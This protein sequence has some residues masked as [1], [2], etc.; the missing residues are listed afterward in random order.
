MTSSRPTST[1]SAAHLV[2][3]YWNMTNEHFETPLKSGDFTGVELDFPTKYVHK[4]HGGTFN[5]LL[6]RM[7]CYN[8][9]LIDHTQMINEYPDKSGLCFSRLPVQPIV[10]PRI[11]NTTYF[12]PYCFVLQDN[13]VNCCFFLQCCSR[14]R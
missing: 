13:E 8:R 3:K 6:L 4:H 10:N 2:N 5:S 11:I 12:S 1:F 7:I 9:S 14:L